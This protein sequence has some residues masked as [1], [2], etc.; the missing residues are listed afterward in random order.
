M[1]P[2]TAAAPYARLGPTRCAPAVPPAAAIPPSAPLPP[3]LSPLPPRPRLKLSQVS[4]T[5]GSGV[6]GT[7]TPFSAPSLGAPQGKG[8]KVRPLQETPPAFPKSRLKGL[9]TVALLDFLSSPSQF[10]LLF[11]LTAP[12]YFSVHVPYVCFW[13]Y[14]CD[15]TIVIC[16]PHWT[17]GSREKGPVVLLTMG[18]GA[19]LVTVC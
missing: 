17:V 10:L 15:S 6:S 18:S 11:L 5:M 9:V 13:L 8:R 7:G 19:R 4:P 3:P 2:D 16:R 1:S 12:S 14:L